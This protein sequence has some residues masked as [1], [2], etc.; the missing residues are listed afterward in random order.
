M[1][2]NARANLV[3]KTTA[4]TATSGD[5]YL[6]EQP[7]YSM[8]CCVALKIFCSEFYEFLGKRV[9]EEYHLKN[10]DPKLGISMDADYNLVC[11]PAR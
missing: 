3:T 6:I 10:T 4:A 11:F 5:N 7:V 2:V 1:W 8:K 9:F